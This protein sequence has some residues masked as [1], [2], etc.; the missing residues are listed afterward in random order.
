MTITATDLTREHYQRPGVRNVILRYCVLESGNGMRALNAD[1]HWYTGGHDPATVVLRGPADYDATIKRGKT[2][3]A[4]LDILEPSVFGQATRWDE[5][6]KAP[7]KPIGE[8]SNCLAFTLSTDIDGIGDI[9]KDL[10]VK[11]AVEAAG[12]FHVDYLRER[13]I[14]N[15]VYCL[16]SGGGIYVHLHHALFAVDVGNTDL[17][18]EEIKRQYQ[19]VTKA[20]NALIGDISQ[21]FFRKYP[22]YIGKVKFD[23]LNNQKRTFK[24]IL[25]LH[26][27]L[28][29][30]V[31]PLDPKAI[32]IDFSRASLPI[33]DEVLAECA[34]WYKSYDLS[35]KEALV[36]LLKDKIDEIKQII[37]DRPTA[38]D[39]T[40]SRLPEPLDRATFAPCIKNIIEKAEDHEGKHR[41]LGILATYLF[42]MGWNEDAAFDLW[43]EVAN[44][45]RV[46]PR[47]FDTTFGIVS[48]PLCSTI[49]TDTGGYPHLNLF[50]MGFCVPDENCKGCQWPGDYHLQ[51]ILNEEP[52]ST[53][54]NDDAKTVLARE[55]EVVASCPIRDRAAQLEK[56]VRVLKKFVDTGALKISDVIHSLSEAADRSG[57]E[58]DEITDII[59]QVLFAGEPGQ[60]SSYQSD[61]A[62][63][64]AEAKAA[65]RKEEPILLTDVANPTKN[66]DPEL[67]ATKAAR[68]IVKK[69]I[70]AMSVDS[71]DIY[72][73]DGQIY[74]PDG[75]RK[76]NML[77]CGLVGDDLDIK[78]LKEILRRVR[79]ELLDNPVVFEPD[80][81][82]LPVKNG[83]ANL[84]TGE[85]RPYHPEDLM[86]EQ[87][88]INHDPAARC[89]AFLAFLESITPN[90]SDRLTLIDWFVSLS[91]KEPLPYVLFLL[92]L[93]RNGK[94][95]YEKL[96]KRFFGQAAFRDMP[97]AEVGKNNFAAGGFYRKRGWIA[98]ETGKRKAGIG[99][100]FIKLTSGNGTIDADRK[101]QSRI[102]FEPYF[103]AI[104]DT[105]SMP[106]INDSS[107]GWMERFVKVD[108]PYTF[109]AAPDPNNPL[110]KQRDPAL[111]DKLT[112]DGELSG[113]L[114]LL[115]FRSKAIGKSG[116]IHKRS[117]S[118]MFAEYQE[119]SSSVASFLDMFCEYDGALSGLWTPSGQIY[120]AYCEWCRYKVGEVVDKAYFGRQLKKF[121][122]GFAPKQGKDANRKTQT[123]YKGLKFGENRYQAA[124]KTLM[125]E[126]CPK[127]SEVV[128][129][130]DKSQQISMSEVSEVNVWNEIKEKF[131]ELPKEKNSS[132]KERDVKIPQTPQTPQTSASS[133][134]VDGE[135]TSDIG[136]TLPQ[137]S[138]GDDQ[139]GIAPEEVTSSDFSPEEAALLTRICGRMKQQ[140]PDKPINP[141]ELAILTKDHDIGVA[142]CK[143]WI[144]REAGA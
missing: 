103:Q 91:I 59:M 39:S 128:S 107:K 67:S 78:A 51:K 7:E 144:A 12:Q 75:A 9:S 104:V 49:Q 89:P 45:C 90:T 8:L 105:N 79:N 27:R 60:K 13:G 14:T 3:Y 110:E 68:A 43:A 106:Q 36:S 109:L 72:Q 135:P 138:D 34:A 63:D 15:N 5:A 117:G 119:Q 23:Q 24:T 76:I 127:M 108:L 111:F 70:L 46:E 30:A 102:Q 132:Y 120:E 21:A 131:G 64:E 129:E 139:T 121:C 44:R 95:I 61:A 136:Q 58:L 99:T 31:I 97:L 86:M 26:K 98:S 16:Y 85:V 112:T 62:A 114:N 22:E 77:L 133:E 123:E 28:P 100:D 143:A 18:P 94:G 130:V 126:V 11:E 50:Q 35:E 69:K 17:A 96:L 10:S 53:S 4:T 122:G 37:R 140:H 93:G 88:D 125:S 33:S 20:Y 47:I 142:R 2:L 137:T 55:V 66:G 52:K 56:S 84:L 92:G 116:Q 81:Y 65:T 74:R 32:K 48:C 25:S 1:E 83:V 124:L 19:I 57:L 29:Y 82:L 6:R 141:F 41:A 115:L 38:E 118:E 80:P 101:N 113:I 87:L 40:I 54:Q 134:L 71:D 42:Q 73:F